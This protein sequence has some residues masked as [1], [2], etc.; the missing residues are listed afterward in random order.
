M[1]DTLM[2]I[3]ALQEI[4]TE[5][6]RI[7]RLQKA[8]PLEQAKAQEE[9]D[10]AQSVYTQMEQE[11]TT[12]RMKADESDCRVKACE[13]EMEKLKAKLRTIKNNKEFE[14]IRDGINSVEERKGEC[15]TLT[16]ETLQAV[17][18]AE[19]RLASAKEVLTEKQNALAAVSSEVAAEAESLGQEVEAIKLRR[20]AQKEKLSSETLSLYETAIRAGKGVAVVKM[21]KDTCQGCFREQRPNT[22]VQ[23]MAATQLVRCEGCGRFLYSENEEQS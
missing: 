15:E 22:R 20:N 1:N 11:I 19:A 4:D 21:H 8:G 3:I 2:N 12:L 7:R 17:E 13:E 23:V 16:L 18:D 5:V 14:I 10:K 6:I 9:T